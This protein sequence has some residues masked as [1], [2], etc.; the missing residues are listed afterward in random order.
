MRKGEMQLHTCPRWARKHR[1]EEALL[2]LLQEQKGAQAAASPGSP[3]S[4]ATALSSGRLNLLCSSTGHPRA[5][6]YSSIWAGGLSH[7]TTRGQCC[8]GSAPRLH[9]REPGEE[10]PESCQGLTKRSQYQLGPV[11]LGEDWRGAG[12]SGGRV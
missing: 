10:E 9:K 3:L 12:I 4:L 8:A 11:R 6:V 1:G 5:Q 7:F 2:G